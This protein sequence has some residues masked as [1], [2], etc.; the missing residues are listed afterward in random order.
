[1]RDT[2]EPSTAP[3]PPTGRQVLV[4]TLVVKVGDM[5]MLD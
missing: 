3:V 4:F 1:M 5:S 2:L